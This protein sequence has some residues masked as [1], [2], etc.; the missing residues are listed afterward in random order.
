MVYEARVLDTVGW[1]PRTAE[2]PRKEEERV[3]GVYSLLSQMKE[4]LEWS[5]VIPSQPRSDRHWP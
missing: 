4:L 1:W 5:V 3:W 2:L